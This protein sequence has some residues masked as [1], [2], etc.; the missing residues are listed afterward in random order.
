MKK[1]LKKYKLYIIIGVSIL[2]LS[3]G[4]TLAYY[5]WS[6]TTNAIVNAEVCTPEMYFTGGSTVNGTNMI[7]VLSK[8]EGLTKQIEVKVNNS[9]KKGT[10][11]SLYL[12]LETFPTEL[13]D[14]SFVYELYKNGTK[15]T[16][17]NFSNR[18]EGNTITLISD[19]TVTS[20]K[21]T[22]TLYVYIDGNQDNPGTMAG[23]NFSL[24]L[25][26]SGQGAIY[27]ENVMGDY[28]SSGSSSLPAE[29]SAFLGSTKARNTIQLVV[30]E[31][32]NVV[33]N[34]AIE[35]VDISSLK[36]G[37]VM[38]WYTDTDSNG[39]Y[40]AHIGSSTG[41]IKLN[42][43][44]EGL[45]ANLTEVESID[46]S[47]FDTSN[48]TNMSSMF[49]E[50]YT[51]TSLNLS[52]FD[53]SNVTN[54]SYMLSECYALTSLNL[55]NFDTSKVTDMSYMFNECYALT[56][57]N[58]SNF[59]TSK[60]TNMSYMLSD[61]NSLTSLNLSNFDTSKVTDM[62]GMFSYCNSLTSLNLSNFDT[63]NVTN[64]SYMLSYCNSLTSLDLSNFDTSKVTSMSYMF[65]GCS[66]FTSLNLSSLDTSKVTD[67]SNM[68]SGCSSFTSLDLSNFDTSK[69]TSMSNMFNGCS[70]F[71]SL[72]LSNFDTS[73]VI[74]ISGMFYGCSSLT[75]LDL[76]NFNTSKVT[77]MRAMFQ[78][79]T[80]LT[81][82]DLSNFNTSKVTNMG[83]MFVNCS[84]LKTIY[85]SD[86]W[87]TS[88]VTSST[89]MFSSCTSL[90]GAV[91]YDSTK[92]DISMANY[93]TGYLTYKS[94]N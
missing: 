45:F 50:C 47:S 9:C 42:T 56:S 54:M 51:L 16:N 27:K 90:V 46:L 82:L 36:D 29:T 66:S 23:K 10:T 87:N 76:S 81:S 72:D 94:N 70:S 22:Y 19:A 63:S 55:S 68:F 34:D 93:T 75:S 53:T 21:D 18:E 12:D 33:P 28:S 71:T 58:L 17:G 13:A 78:S 67:M 35:S 11:M 43:N 8:E 88:S 26:A 7:P 60:V 49:E 14:A 83:Y 20:T 1:Y 84:K 44:A 61:C 41:I 74:Y 85:V 59:D 25:W 91:S 86:L 6:S 3:V 24:K 48:V 37:S 2:I 52:S 77:S 57:L 30:S 65:N 73:N 4:G 31:N 64:M 79:C 69:V 38:L 92:T 32:N 15:V 89:N 62:S 5:I 80:K 40:E 39:L